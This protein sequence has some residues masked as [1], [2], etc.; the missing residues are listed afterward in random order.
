MA[1]LPLWA[2]IRAIKDGLSARAGLRAY[3]DGGGSIR[4]S[5]WYQLVG[6]ARRNLSD[7][8]DESLRP[9]NRRP[10][11]G[12]IN[13]LPTRTA[14][15]FIQNVDVYVQDRTSGLVE[16]RPWSIRTNELLSRRAAINDAVTL[17]GDAALAGQYDEVVLGATYTG[18]FELSPM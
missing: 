11:V 6:T 13:V 18:T 17:F 12:E 1:D 10:T 7:G 14:T 15:G 8:L 3:R 9:L 5:T 4:D 16:I 2:A